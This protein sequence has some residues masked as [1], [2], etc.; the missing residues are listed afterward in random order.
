M[1]VSAYVITEIF[2]EVLSLSSN[3]PFILMI[4]VLI[5]TN[6]SMGDI[7]L[8][9]DIDKDHLAMYPYCGSMYQGATQAKSRA[10]NSENSK[11]D[12]R[13]TAFL[14]RE[15]TEP[16]SKKVKTT[17]CSGSIITDR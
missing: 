8:N 4:V 16:K 10:I 6:T 17:Y 14:L 7:D 13:W 15:N 12:Y 2:E 11:E 9:K 5:T 3:M 1:Q